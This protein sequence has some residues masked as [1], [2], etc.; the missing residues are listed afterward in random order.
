MK[1]R[2]TVF[3]KNNGLVGQFKSLDNNDMMNLKGG[4][5]V[6]T[7]PLPSSGGDDYPILPKAALTVN[8]NTVVV[9]TVKA[10]L[11]AAASNAAI[12]LS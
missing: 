8:T 5:A 11:P 4:G 3:S 7:P 10:N 2:S 1:N 9:V 6:V 12:S